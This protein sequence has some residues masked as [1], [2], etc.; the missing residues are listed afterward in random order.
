MKFFISKRPFL[1]NLWLCEVAHTPAN[2]TKLSNIL[3]VN[4]QR[5]VFCGWICESF[6]MA[7]PAIDPGIAAISAAV[8][9]PTLFKL[10]TTRF[11]NSSREIL[12]P[13]CSS[14]NSL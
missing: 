1:V 12:I 9:A 10:S 3:P 11:S 4:A 14:Q 6:A 13:G 2:A 7:L 5:P 8:A